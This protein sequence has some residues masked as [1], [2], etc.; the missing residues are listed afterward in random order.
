LVD[1]TARWKDRHISKVS[2]KKEKRGVPDSRSLPV[3]IIAITS[4]PCDTSEPRGRVGKEEK[5]EK[6]FDK[7]LVH[8]RN[9]LL[10]AAIVGFPDELWRLE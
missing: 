2:E 10:R 9:T 8:G 5:G 3:I 6:V 7:L 4:R 1:G